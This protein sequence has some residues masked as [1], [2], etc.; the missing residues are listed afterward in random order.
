MSRSALVLA[1]LLVATTAAA[2]SASAHGNDL[3]PTDGNVHVHE[4]VGT[5]N[6]PWDGWPGAEVA[7][8]C[9]TANATDTPTD[10]CSEDHT[11]DP[12]Y[13]PSPDFCLF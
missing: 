9:T 10:N 1:F 11:V 3:D 6:D 13:C 7:V 5:P 8:T 4:K 12:K 2:G